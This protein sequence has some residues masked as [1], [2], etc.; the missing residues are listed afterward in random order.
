MPPNAFVIRKLRKY[1]VKYKDGHTEE[2]NLVQFSGGGEAGNIFYLQQLG[3]NNFCIYT[4]L[5]NNAP[6]SSDI[7]TLS[8]IRWTKK[9]VLTVYSVPGESDPLPIKFYYLQP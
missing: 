7:E 2:L 9:E 1:T 4:A 5:D 6:S 3:E 8:R